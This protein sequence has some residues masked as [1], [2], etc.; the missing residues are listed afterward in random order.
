MHPFQSGSAQPVQRT[1]SALQTTAP[2]LEVPAKLQ[3]VQLQPSATPSQPSMMLT[4]ATLHK[5]DASEQTPR[6][7]ARDP[8]H[9]SDEE[10]GSEDSVSDTFFTDTRGTR[11]RGCFSPSLGCFGVDGDDCLSVGTSQAITDGSSSMGD[12][13]AAAGTGGVSQ[14]RAG[15]LMACSV[16]GTAPTVAFVGLHPSQDAEPALAPLR[17]LTLKV[18]YVGVAN[19]AVRAAFQTAGFN[20]TSKPQ[21]NV[22]WSKALKPE[23]YSTLTKFQRANH[24]PG[25][26][27]LG[28]K[29]KLYTNIARAKRNTGSFY[30]VIPK[31]YILPRDRQELKQH[32][33]AHPD[34]LYIQ[35]PLAS[36]RGRGIRLVPDPGAIPAEKAC[37]VQHY[38]S[39]PHTINGLKYDL[40]VYALVTCLNPL[41]VYL[42]QE[43][44]VRFAS[45]PFTLHRS[46]LRRRC[47]HVTN[48]SVNKHQPGFKANTD[49]DGDGVG[50]KWS[51]R[52]LQEHLERHCGVQWNRIWTQVHDLVMAAILA[53]EP[54]LHSAARMHVPHR[55]N[56]FEIFGVDVLLDDTFRAWL[57]EVNT[58]PDLSSTSPLDKQLKHKMVA[59]MMHLVG[60]VPYDR[61][62]YL[63]Q[64]KLI[65][66]ARLTGLPLT[67]TANPSSGGRPLASCGSLSVSS[68]RRLVSS[69]GTRPSCGDSAVLD[70]L[71]Q[72]QS[73]L[74]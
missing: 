19:N 10:M 62:E 66:T 36:S 21:W 49:A 72:S 58:G 32:A 7:E 40:R 46:K 12:A 42:Y 38:V 57:I 52:A 54:E 39:N 48:Y 14:G 67:L 1:S 17:G 35:K 5:H 51:L 53:A 59:Q 64:Q 71:D 43:G 24:F 25:T 68:T 4:S 73:E 69:G 6:P 9:A 37:L 61:E 23:A 18:K 31:F 50:S 20:K 74:Q 60:V 28:R 33:A 2:A 34:Q 30:N 3:P 55:A 27:Q 13:E 16:M 65:Q 56:C 29:D 22:L 70:K 41:R 26:W 8:S 44:L 45:E 15:P 11:P 63:M 47:V